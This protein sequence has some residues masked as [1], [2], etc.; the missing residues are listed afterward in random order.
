MTSGRF[1]TDKSKRIGK[2]LP[3][4]L[5]ELDQICQGEYARATGGNYTEILD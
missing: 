4:N 5:S 3:C 1:I 2:E